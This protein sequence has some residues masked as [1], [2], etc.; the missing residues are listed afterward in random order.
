MRNKSWVNKLKNRAIKLTNEVH[1]IYLA[2]K[3]ERVSWHAKLLIFLILAYAISPIDLIPDFIP[4]LG[5]LD[6]LIIVPLGI[7]L[8]IKIIPK[9]VL[10]EYRKK[11]RYKTINNKNTFIGIF[12]IFLIWL[13]ILYLFFKFVLHFI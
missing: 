2:S 3:D 11:A 7:S 4:V 13:F 10:D 12:I 5:Q 9:N 8:L 6:D 1:A